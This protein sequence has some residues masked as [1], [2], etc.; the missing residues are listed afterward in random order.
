MKSYILE[1]VCSAKLAEEELGRLLPQNGETWLLQNAMQ[2]VVAYFQVLA[3][4]PA[5]EVETPAVIAD[6]SGRHYNSDEAVLSV[7]KALQA[8]VRGTIVYAP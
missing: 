6:I 1:S 2:D 4:D 3:T 8:K 7:L 5:L